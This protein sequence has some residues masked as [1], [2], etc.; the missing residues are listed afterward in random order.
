MTIRVKARWFNKQK[1]R[2]PEELA[3]TL[4]FIV[5][6]VSQ[7]MIKS[8]RN[9]GFDIDVGPSYFKFFDE[10]L[11]FFATATDRLVF[12]YLLSDERTRFTTTLVVRLAENVN[13]SK[14][15]WLGSPPD[16][17]QSWSNQFI[18]LYNQLGEHY[19]EFP[20]GVRE[21]EFSMT[22]YFGSRLESVLPLKDQRWIKDQVIAYEVPT[23]IALLKKGIFGMFPRTESIANQE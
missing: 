14:L 5:W 6:R 17:Q 9:A 16:G 1:A 21:L 8:S 10:L 13:E 19:S 23:A 4:A 20:N 11:V 18:D 2:K 7:N 22:R 3:S 12:E 15:E